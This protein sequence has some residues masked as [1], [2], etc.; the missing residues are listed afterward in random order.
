MRRH[1]S[2]S[3][4]EW[5]SPR[6]KSALTFILHFQP[7][8]LRNKC[9]FCYS[10]PSWL[11]QA[12]MQLHIHM[13]TDACTWLYVHT[14]P[15]TWTLPTDGHEHMS[16][17][18]PRESFMSL[19]IDTCVQIQK[20]AH[21]HAHTQMHMFTNE[22]MQNMHIDPSFHSTPELF[23]LGHLVKSLYS[24]NKSQVW[25]RPSLSCSFHRLR[26]W[27]ALSERH[28]KSHPRT[29]RWDSCSL[30]RWMEIHPFTSACTSP[31]LRPH[32]LEC[33]KS[34]TWWGQRSQWLKFWDE[35]RKG[36]LESGT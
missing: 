11:T 1:L 26:L 21:E 16:T 7:P 9:W 18:I 14:W 6:T 5:W 23:A 28:G 12:Y 33:L 30:W 25:N 13:G 29:P 10:I 24:V 15:H 2:V 19:P 31:P 34:G 17:C 20:C 35:E 22:C 4:E 27:V 36:S 8:E 3:Q 32:A